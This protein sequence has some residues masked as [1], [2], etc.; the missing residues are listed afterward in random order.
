[1]NLKRVVRDP[2]F[3]PTKLHGKAIA[4]IIATTTSVKVYKKPKR[5][6][7]PV[8]KELNTFFTYMMSQKY[9]ICENCGAE[10]IYLLKEENKALWKSC[11][12]HLFP[13]RHFESIKC[14]P[15]NILVL[16]SGY[17][18]LCNCHDNYDSNWHKA[19]TMRVWHEVVLRFHILYPLIKP[20]EH[21]FIPQQLLDTL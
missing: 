10:N 13:K 4:P 11:M 2:F 21:Q 14:H 12:A 20:E 1:V 16:G 6:A 18:G 15:L 7:K 17:S 9:P 5:K 19:S 8:D 3:L